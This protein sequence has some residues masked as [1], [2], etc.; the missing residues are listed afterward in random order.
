MD[1][2]E[3]SARQPNAE[4]EGN[5][6]PGS[7]TA[8]LH[9]RISKDWTSSPGPV[10]EGDPRGDRRDRLGQRAA[11]WEPASGV[12]ELTLGLAFGSGRPSGQDRL[13]RRAPGVSPQASDGPHATGFRR[14]A[15]RA[16]I[17]G[18]PRHRRKR[19]RRL[20]RRPCGHFDLRGLRL[21][22][23]TGPEGRKGAVVAVIG[24]GALTAGMAFE[25]LNHAGDVGIDLVVIINDNEMSI[26][27]NVGA[28]SAH[29]TRLRMDQTIR[30]ARSD[31]ESVIKKI[32]GIGEPMVKSA[33]RL[34]DTLI[35]MVT[36]GSLFEALGFSY[37]G[38]IDGHNI[39]LLQRVI[40]MR[41]PAGARW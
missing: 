21:C 17:S 25:A 33:E 37:Y 31:L 39:P 22:H 11:I 35:H 1:R 23:R 20:W 13:G 4:S 12:V 34:K 6:C 29:L 3:K 9:P 26:S 19:I 32:P 5:P 14:C 30:R 15:K 18:F 24:D 8:S 36:P 40:P 38:P 28:L 16:G 10:G 2:G 27:P 41:W 7:W